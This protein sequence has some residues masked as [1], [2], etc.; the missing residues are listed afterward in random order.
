MCHCGT[1]L[2][3][4]EMRKEAGSG[5]FAHIQAHLGARFG[6]QLRIELSMNIARLARG[7]SLYLVAVRARRALCAAK[8]EKRGF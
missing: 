2:R 4:D 3:F 5:T 6:D 8:A 1:W 7:V